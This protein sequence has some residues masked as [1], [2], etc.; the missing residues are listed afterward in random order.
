MEFAAWLSQ[1]KPG[2]IVHED[3]KIGTVISV[4]PALKVEWQVAKTYSAITISIL[5]D[6]H[7][8]ETEGQ[9]ELDC[10]NGN[11]NPLHHAILFLRKVLGSLNEKYIQKMGKI[12]YDMRF[13]G[14]NAT[15]LL[16]LDNVV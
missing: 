4:D 9:E 6:G 5:P 1:F 13:D 10:E 15:H 14:P 11:T 7:E 12:L 16:N 2:K 8:K 3:Q